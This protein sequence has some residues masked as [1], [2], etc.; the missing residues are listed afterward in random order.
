[1]GL[2]WG[3][4]GGAESAISAYRK[5]V[6]YRSL[7]KV[8]RYIPKAI[9]RPLFQISTALVAP[10]PGPAQSVTAGPLTVAG[11]LTATTGLGEGARLCLAALSHCGYETNY[12]D[13]S[14]AFLQ[15]DLPTVRLPGQAAAAGE[16]GALIAHLNPHMLPFT[17]FLM[18]QDHIKKKRVIGYWAWEL[19]A[20]PP[21]WKRGLKYVHDIW[22]PSRF[23]AEAFRPHT[24]LP[25]YVIPHPVP[26]PALADLKRADFGLADDSFVVLTMFHMQSGFVRKNPI[27]AVTSF[28]LAFGDDP[29]VC[30]V[31]KIADGALQPWA[32]GEIEKAVGTAPNIRILHDK[33]SREGVAAL[34]ACSDVVIS[35]HRS[36]GFGLV[37]AQ[38]MRLG[39]P[40]IATAWSGNMDFMNPLNS[41][42]VD[43][44]LVPV[45]DPQGNYTQRDQVWADPDIEQAAQW[46][47]RLANDR[48]LRARIGQTAAQETAK[49]FSITAYGE[50]VSRALGGIP[51]A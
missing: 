36:E 34:I 40:V 43:Y 46:L 24:E 37:L 26:S 12:L 18:G 30:L 33:L 39:K 29:K 50:A 35:L 48:A 3:L 47:D 15:R 13:L 1:M 51:F 5:A 10:R 49:R 32:L 42:L 14:A 17:L 9:R 31:I 20:I 38:A 44:A 11:F 41:A 4:T 28:R 16:G 2:S 21:R 25:I 6:L 22:V 45:H 19:P 8:W 23:T 7:H 27:A